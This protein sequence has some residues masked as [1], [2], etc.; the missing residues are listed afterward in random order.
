MV[1]PKTMK[2]QLIKKLQAA[3][4]FN[5]SEHVVVALSGGFDS[6]HLATWLTDGSLPLTMQPKVSV[7]YINHQLR[8]D[9]AEEEAFVR[10]WLDQ[11]KERFVHTAIQRIDWAEIPQHGIEEQA[12]ER[13]YVLLKQQALKW[14]T[15]IIVTAHHQD[16]Q[17]ETM[18]FKLLRGSHLQQLMGMSMRQIRDGL[19]LRRPFLGLSK[20]ELPK[21]V[22]KPI[23]KVIEDSSN[24]DQTYA[25]NRL[26]QSIIPEL[27]QIN[28]KFAPHLLKTMDQLGTLL[29]LADPILDAQAH[30]IEMGTFDWQAIEAD[31][32]ILVL[33]KWINQQQEYEIKDQQLY[34][35]IK[36]MQNPN[37]N[38]GSV[39]ISHDLQA[40]R[41]KRQLTL[42]KVINQSVLID[43]S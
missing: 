30:E 33:Q 6:L 31:V 9:A 8:A 13:R 38:R 42:Q 5:S 43:N 2:M 32:Q 40:V 14:D 25:R 10:E 22:E 35:I 21:L 19:D 16:D 29:K 27:K 4:L 28:H 20:A 12:R 7:I 18:L 17:V 39:Q 3:E 26:R 1:Q 24:Y 41:D 15:N 36:L 34:Q 37:V 23:L 11:N